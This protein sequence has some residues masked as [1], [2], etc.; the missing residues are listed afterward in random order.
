M[1]RLKEPLNGSTTSSEMVSEYQITNGKSDAAPPEGKTCPRAYSKTSRGI[2]DRS[3]VPQ[4]KVPSIEDAVYIYRMIMNSG[5]RPPIFLQRS[6]TYLAQARKVQR[7]TPKSS[8]DLESLV[9]KLS[10]MAAMCSQVQLTLTNVLNLR[11]G[12]T[13]KK[14]VSIE[15]YLQKNCYKRRKTDITMKEKFIKK[16]L[17][18]TPYDFSADRHC[19]T[20]D[21]AELSSNIGSHHMSACYL[22]AKVT[23]ATERKPSQ[24]PAKKTKRRYY[25]EV[26]E[27]KYRL[28]E[29][30]STLLLHS[31]GKSYLPS[32]KQTLF[33]QEVESG[34]HMTPK[35]MDWDDLSSAPQLVLESLQVNQRKFTKPS[36]ERPNLTNTTQIR[37]HVR[38]QMDLSGQAAQSLHEEGDMPSSQTSASAS[39]IT[40]SD[41]LYFVLQY[42]GA[43][44][45][46]VQ[47]GYT[48]PFCLKKTHPATLVLLLKHMRLC[49]NRLLF[50]YKEM[51]G[52][53][54]ITVTV[55]T[56]YDGSYSGNPL[57]IIPSQKQA[58]SICES[59]KCVEPMRR[60]P[61]TE[62][63]N[64]RADRRPLTLEEF[65]KHEPLPLIS[66]SSA[67]LGHNRLYYHSISNQPVLSNDFDTDSD[68]EDTEWCRIASSRLID[69]FIDVN[70]GEKELMKLWNHFISRNPVYICDAQMEG[71]CLRFIRE[72]SEIVSFKLRN[73]FLCHLATLY[74]S[75]V[76]QTKHIKTIIDALPKKAATGIKAKAVVNGYATS[77][78]RIKLEPLK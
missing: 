59:F 61:Y 14:E 42:K 4:E 34:Q 28:K 57:D 71:A 44:Q 2:P 1:K 8:E 74:D 73:N 29:Y 55:N 64:I 69:D 46:T 56:F 24:P 40:K 15:F 60:A 3:T 75:G 51:E 33:L 23:V 76:L 20:L 68:G 52:E 11:V 65:T 43:P 5:T 35:F 37:G 72:H 12:P 13:D 45:T 9:Q 21:A 67:L 41:Q 6:L 50:L 54:A 16:I 53:A 77:L 26:P 27:P 47:V 70:K 78:S 25:P 39:D 19:I 66:S 18:V 49:H 48:C 30:V 58:P 7:N 10:N 22:K 31:G 38:A 32:G 17:L 63:L 62:V 36:V